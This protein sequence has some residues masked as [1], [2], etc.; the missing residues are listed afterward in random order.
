MI[1]RKAT[2]RL[3]AGATASGQDP[4]APPLVGL[5]TCARD[6]NVRK[7]YHIPLPP[8]RQLRATFTVSALPGRLLGAVMA[9]MEDNFYLDKAHGG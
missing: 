2:Y 7:K 3:T 9:Q 8:R 1:N 5:N 6:A 4:A